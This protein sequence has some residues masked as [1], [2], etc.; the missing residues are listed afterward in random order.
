MVLGG[1]LECLIIDSLENSATP[2]FI[3]PETKLSLLHF[4]R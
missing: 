2:R 1:G 3:K 4:L